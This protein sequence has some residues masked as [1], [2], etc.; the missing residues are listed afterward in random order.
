[1]TKNSPVTTGAE[2]LLDYLVYTTEYLSMEEIREL[3]NISRRTAF[4][5]LAI[6]NRK[7]ISE[8]LTPIINIPRYGYK[9]NDQARHQ[10]AQQH[11]KMTP[12]S[13]EES[14]N[15]GP[16]ERRT[17]IIWLLLQ[18]Q[19][20]I[21]INRL[22]EYFSC[23]RNTII[24]D[25][26]ELNLAFPK[27]TIIST[28]QGRKIDSAERTVR[29]VIYELLQR[30]NTAM[31]KFIDT[32]NYSVTKY[33]Q[34][35]IDCQSRLHMNFSENAI[36]QLTYLLIFSDWRI[37]QGKVIQDESDYYWIVENTNGVISTCENIMEAIFGKTYDVGEVIF[38]SKVV[39]CSQ[40]TEM[41]CVNAS[42]YDDLNDISQEIIFRYEQL[43]GEKVS[44]KLFTKVL[45]NHL[46]STF[47]RVK[48]EIP[49]SSSEIDAIKKRYPRLVKFTAIACDPLEHYLGKRLPSNEV[50]LIC[51]Y[52]GPGDSNE[53]QDLQDTDKFK[54]ASLAEVL[55]V[56]SSGIGT[57]VMLYNELSK[58]YPL[59]K[60]SLPL[61]IRELP[62]IFRL[63]YQAQLIIST[64]PLDE[65]DYQIPVVNVKAILT[66]HDQSLIEAQFRNKLPRKIEHNTNVVSHLLEIINDYATVNDENGLRL[67]LDKFIFP[68]NNR[69]STHTDRPSLGSILP[70]NHIKLL[71]N[72][73][74]LTWDEVLKIGCQM[75]EEDQIIESRYYSEIQKLINQYG[76]YMLIANNIFLAHAAPSQGSKTVGLSL[77]LLDQP[78]KITAKNQSVYVTCI[79]VL[80]P[81][82][83]HEHERALTELIDIVRNTDNVKKLLKASTVQDV[84]EIII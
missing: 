23:S 38:L 53:Y 17:E 19:N 26:K 47:F 78:L 79:F 45:C 34:I 43:T 60:F 48:F 80:S 71:H 24:K 75:L 52:F 11:L 21:S 18:G 55:V 2:R 69:E 39:L 14:L 74:Q 44:Y 62:E 77:V 51:L 83:K 22:S 41:D 25:F 66:E 9:L 3:F 57:S 30:H 33:E 61:E 46:Y 63:N 49:F 20:N 5:W 84:R 32:L 59:I 82:L 13:A 1:M 27:L 40:A 7:L 54:R 28:H 65:N 81:G 16:Q 72:N 56:C 70:A 58:T 4:N 37:R 15:L 12:A 50:A 64:A 8:K 36:H 10:L 68:D 31:F 29:L 73:G 67:S 35:I 6:I 42:L 76:P